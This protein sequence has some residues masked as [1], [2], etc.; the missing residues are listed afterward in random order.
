[1]RNT[2]IDKVILLK[3]CSRV[4]DDGVTTQGAQATPQS[5]A[6]LVEPPGNAPSRAGS[7][8]ASMN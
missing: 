6:Q 5:E 1:M 7:H 4:L 2:H 3:N 8:C